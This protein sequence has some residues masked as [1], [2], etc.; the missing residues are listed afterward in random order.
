MKC[1]VLKPSGDKL[2][3]KQ[4]RAIVALLERGTIKEA[5]EACQVSDVTLWRWLQ[6]E[7]FLSRYRAV[8][9]QVIESSIARLQ[10]SSTVAVETL[11]E[12]ARDKGAPAAARVSASRVIL[13]QGIKGVETIDTLERLARLE[14]ILEEH[15]KRRMNA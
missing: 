11:E 9:R 12:I 10:Q 2:T 5:A 6:D 3:A 14:A 15:K 7:G 13:E 8:R 1:K 4:E